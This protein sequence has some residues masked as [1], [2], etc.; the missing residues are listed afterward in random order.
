MGKA[1]RFM[2]GMKVSTEGGDELNTTCG[3]NNPATPFI[4]FLDSS[5]KR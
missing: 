4:N 1:L 2:S 3:G 5:Q